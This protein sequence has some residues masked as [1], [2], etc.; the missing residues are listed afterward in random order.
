MPRSAPGVPRKPSPA[1]WVQIAQALVARE[2]VESFGL[3]E[4]PAAMLL[5]I[6]PSS[7]SQYLSG[8]RLGNVLASYRQDA[9]ARSIARRT[10]ERLAKRTSR[11]AEP[12]ILLETAIRLSRHFAAGARTK[13][14]GPAELPVSDRLDPSL[15]RW[16]RRRIAAE[17][18][19]VTQC[20]RLAQKSRDELTRAIFRQIA[21]DSLRHAEIVGSL[22]SYLDRGIRTP[23]ASGITVRDIEQ[24]I[25]SERAAESGDDPDRSRSMGGLLSIL[26]ESMEFDERKHDRLLDLLRASALGAEEDL[27]PGRGERG[28]KSH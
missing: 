21:S 18:E 7:V 10:A 27:G 25:A 15:R 24:L 23:T 28:R 5:G 6:V 20:M 2:L 14:V 22:G 3:A 13:A 11:G 16:M 26:W 17:Q 1:G 19:A 9:E 12:E 4:R 8:K